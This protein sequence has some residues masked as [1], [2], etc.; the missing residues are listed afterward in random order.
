VSGTNNMAG[1]KFLT[2]SDING[3]IVPMVTPFK[4]KN[5]S[6][7]DL[8]A[9]AKLTNYLIQGGIHALMPLGTSGEFALQDR[10]ERREV[11]STVV[12][13]AHHR[14]PVIA[15]VSS[16][17]TRDA[18]NLAK[19][20]NIAGADAIIAT[21]PYYFK[22]SDE[23]LFDHYEALE[24]ESEVPL[25][26]YN[27]PSWVGYCIP[28][29]V[30]KRLARAH[31]GRVLGVKFT[32][33][34]LSEFLGYLRLLQ[35]DMS[36]MIGADALILPALVLGAAGAV[37]G[38]ANVVPELTSQIFESYMR[39]DLDEAKSLQRKLD[40][41][42]QAMNLG[43]FPA[44]LKAAMKQIGL[45]CGPVRPP[46]LDLDGTD[47]KTVENSIRWKIKSKRN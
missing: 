35:N 13:A 44:G 46:L 17:G 9:L 39:G 19:D 8:A 11:I 43:T 7:I 15:G 27:I 1:M 25:M 32:T 2:K 36:I 37:V 24:T 41:F 20:A 16:P 14:V 31:P 6:E 34:D 40:P 22:T 47:V 29:E 18:I 38:S 33:D 30:V 26:I 42:A 4:G 23:G 5:A 12:K 3:I 45:D 21:G 28:P 10:A